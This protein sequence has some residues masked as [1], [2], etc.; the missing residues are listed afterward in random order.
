MDKNDH[1]ATSAVKCQLHEFALLHA[2]TF[3]ISDMAYQLG[4]KNCFDISGILLYL[5]RNSWF[6]D[7]NVLSTA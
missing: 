5:C 7:F 2:A 4:L 6:L 1:F 3:V